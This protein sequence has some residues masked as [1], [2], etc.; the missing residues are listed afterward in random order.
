VLLAWRL[1]AEWRFDPG[2]LTEVDV[3]FAP[4]GPGATR[5]ALEHRLLENLGAGAN[6][7]RKSYDGAGGWSGLLAAYAEAARA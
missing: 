1:S 5:V 7:A 6:A 4:A 3:R 2:L